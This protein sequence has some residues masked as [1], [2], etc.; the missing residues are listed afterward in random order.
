ML[1][2]LSQKHQNRKQTNHDKWF[3]ELFESQMIPC[4][5]SETPDALFQR[6]CAAW[7]AVLY[8]ALFTALDIVWSWHLIILNKWALPGSFIYINGIHL[9]FQHLRDRKGG[10][11]VQD[12]PWLQRD[13]IQEHKLKRTH[14]Y[15]SRSERQKN[16]LFLK[17]SY[18]ARYLTQNTLLSS[19]PSLVCSTSS[20]TAKTVRQ[21]N[22]V[23]KRN[24]NK[25]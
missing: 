2:T 22:A 25:I 23:L 24:K 6:L 20:S 3:Y 9:E 17:V 16:H 8:P 15:F 14:I 10:L 11:W 5:P 1:H 21:W 4:V 18:I 12:H 7:V 13:L 19:R